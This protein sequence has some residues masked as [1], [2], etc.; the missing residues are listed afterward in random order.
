MERAQLQRL[1]SLRWFAALAVFAGH[2]GLHSGRTDPIF[3]SLALA[4][5]SMFFVLSGIVLTWSS[6]TGDTARKFYRRRFARIYPATVTSGVAAVVVSL[7][8][9]GHVRWSVVAAVAFLL[10]LQAWAPFPAWPIFA[11]NGP[12]WTLSCEAF[13]YS[14]FP[15]LHRWLEKL[16]LRRLVVG[17]AALAVPWFVVAIAVPWPVAAHLPLLRLPEFIIGMVIGIALRRGW[18]PRVR[19][20]AALGVYAALMYVAVE[21]TPYDWIALLP[22]AALVLCA[23]AG[24]DLRGIRSWLTMR[25]S[26]YLGEVSFCF[27]LVHEIAVVN[28]AH[29]GISG[30]WLVSALPVAFLAAAGLH[31]GV[32]LPMQ[33]RILRQPSRLVSADPAL[34]P[35]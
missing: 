32:E 3:G 23:A 14:L 29:M 11:Y 8:V 6:P 28:M 4:G 12:V 21:H 15:W 35:A 33:R 25:W 16:E 31:H 34:S 17:V 2:V 26:V 27:Y 30:W 5:V 22:G 20:G 7:G 24:S 1:T 9:D 18:V 10:L 19:L 13:F